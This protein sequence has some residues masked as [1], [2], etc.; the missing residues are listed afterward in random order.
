M[1]TR[2]YPIAKQGVSNLEIFNL[3]NPTKL[4][5]ERADIFFARKKDYYDTKDS[6]D[7]ERKMHDFYEWLHDDGQEDLNRFSSFE[8]YGF[9]KFTAPNVLLTFEGRYVEPSGSTEDYLT[10][11]AIC[12]LNGIDYDRLEHVLIGFGWC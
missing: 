10:V 5:Q 4:T 2:L 7:R 3:I 11:R 6:N 8:L 12:D 9:G 1:A